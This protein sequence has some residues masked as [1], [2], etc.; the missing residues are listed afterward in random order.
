MVEIKPT[1]LIY[2]YKDNKIRI[3]KKS[4]SKG[5]ISPPWWSYRKFFILF[6]NC[7]FN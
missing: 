5:Y 2:Q 7:Y 4:Q 1:V 6:L 3:V